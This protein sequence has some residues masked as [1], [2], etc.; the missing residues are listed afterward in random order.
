MRE[1][2]RDFLMAMAAVRF[3]CFPLVNAKRTRR[4]QSQNPR[5]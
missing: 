2:R 5:P 1:T 3:I 4:K